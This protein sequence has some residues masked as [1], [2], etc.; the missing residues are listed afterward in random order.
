MN[1]TVPPE[2]ELAYYDVAVKHISN[3]PKEAPC[4]GNL[5]YKLITQSHPEY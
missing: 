5:R 3:Y 2:F 1:V 4:S